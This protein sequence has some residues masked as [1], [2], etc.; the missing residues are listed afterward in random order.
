MLK[1]S[2]LRIFVVVERRDSIAPEQ[3]LVRITTAAAPPWRLP[4]AHPPSRSPVSPRMPACGRQLLD[5]IFASG[6]LERWP[7]RHTAGAR[8]LL[9]WS[10]GSRYPTGSFRSLPMDYPPKR[11]PYLPRIVAQRAP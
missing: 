1:K 5:Q 8:W 7:E 11:W 2:G 9:R 10:A 3:L 6:G 4:C